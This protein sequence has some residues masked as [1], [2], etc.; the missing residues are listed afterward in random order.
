MKKLNL[1]FCKNLMHSDFFLTNQ[2]IKNNSQ[3]IE[4]VVKLGKNKLFS[5]DILNLY[6]EIQ[7]LIR[8]LNFL[9]KNTKNRLN[10]FFK[11]TQSFSFLIKYFRKYPLRLK[12]ILSNTEKLKRNNTKFISSLLF[13]IPCNKNIEKDLIYNKLFLMS[14]IDLDDKTRKGSSLYKIYNKVDTF[15]KFLFIVSLLE[16]TLN[17]K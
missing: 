6:K 2:N 14:L 9:N 11:E 13:L 10:I 1:L 4:K 17:K 7:Q 3:N 8:F 12:I 15:K 16:G 5:L